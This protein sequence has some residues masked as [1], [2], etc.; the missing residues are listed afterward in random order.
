MNQ[1]AAAAA[2]QNQSAY[3]V[4]GYHASVLVVRLLA[5]HSPHSPFECF[6]S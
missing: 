5:V 3:C 2:A 4:C 6:L 1:A